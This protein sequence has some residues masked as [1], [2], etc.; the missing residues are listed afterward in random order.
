M[1]AYDVVVVGAGPAGSLAARQL[2]LAGR[3]VALLDR[4]AFPRAKICGNCLNPRTGRIWRELGLAAAFERLPHAQLTGFALHCEGREL[5]RETLRPPCAGPRAVTRDVFDDWLRREAE[6]AGAHFFP[7][8]TVTGLMPGGVQT[9]QGEFPAQLV[10]AADGRNSVV[11][12]MAGLMP[13]PRRCPRV[14]WQTTIPAPSDLDDHVHMHV[15]EDGYF[16][17]CRCSPDEAVISMVLDSR[18]S[19]D[20]EGAARRLLP[21]FPGGRDWLRMNPITRAPAT[22]LGRDEVWL[23][24]DAAR[25]VEPFTG[26]GM[27]FAL[28]TALLAAR[29]AE[30]ALAT[31]DFTDPLR[32]YAR[33]HQALYRRRAGVNTL[34]RWLLL[35]PARTVRALRMLPF[36]APLVSMLARRVHAT[37]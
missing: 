17:Y 1:T 11:A 14:A 7:E 33:E 25:V 16:G 34:L 24:G 13:E 10:L 29:Q 22:A 8:T 5:Y 21:D 15:S 9:L 6:S 35:E 4:A 30:R 28:E 27:A 26:E 18:R 32:H 31:G 20:P 3:R 37:A 2:A 19:H 36:P 23:V 12:R